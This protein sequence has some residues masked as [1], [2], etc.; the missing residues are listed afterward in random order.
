[1][2][3]P[4]HRLGFTLV[5][6]LVVIG[7]IVVLIGILMPALNLAY[8]HSVRNRMQFDIQTITTALE[9]YRSDHAR[10]PQLDYMDPS[11]TGVLNANYPGAVLLC[12]ALIAPPYVDT[13]VSPTVTYGPGFQVV[14]KGQVYGPYIAADRVKI[15]PDPGMQALQALTPNAPAPFS[16]YYYIADRYGHPILYFKANLNS[17][18]S[19]PG[20]FVANWTPPATTTASPTAP[21]R[22]NMFD[23]SSAKNKT[24]PFGWP[25]DP[26]QTTNALIRMQLMLGDSNANGQIDPGETPATNAPYLLWSAGPDEMFGIDL[27][28]GNSGTGLAVSASYVPNCDDATN[29]KQ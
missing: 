15:V 2:V 19:T 29:F 14:P 13:T 9:Q 22:Y 23:N 28:R 21:P 11:K 4:C 7:V 20:G 24:S 27:S 8:S 25:T 5:E 10:Y 6:M 3:R 26:D 16:A 12:S 17:D 18:P 1:L